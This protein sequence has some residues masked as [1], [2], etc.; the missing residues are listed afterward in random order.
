MRFIYIS[1]S[2]LFIGGCS[3]TQH[4]KKNEK[5]ST[6][7]TPIVIPKVKIATPTPILITP[8]ATATPTSHPTITPTKTPPKPTP[9]SVATPIVLKDKIIE[10][11]KRVIIKRK[12]NSRLA[13][14]MNNLDYILF[15]RVN[16]EVAEGEDD[17]FFTKNGK[18]TLKNFIEDT[19]KVKL[20]YPDAD[21][22]Y[23]KLSK[24]LTKASIKLYKI[25]EAKK[26]EWVKPQVDNIINIC[27]S[28]HDLY[29]F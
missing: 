21:D 16:L 4:I 24:A 26:M 3:L 28:C 20:L 5:S 1:V 8:T 11:K 10:D 18:K 9:T 6:Y 2:I 29:L 14:V 23:I 19:K 13:K 25:V 12:K 27:N 15:S 17:L 22:E 7:P